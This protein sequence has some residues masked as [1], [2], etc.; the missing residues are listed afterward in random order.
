GQAEV[1]SGGYSLA[2]SQ[3]TILGAAKLTGRIGAFS[4]GALNAVTSDED[5]KIVNGDIRTRQTVEPLASYSVV[6]ARR[7]FTNQSSLGFLV[8]S[9]NRNLDAATR[10][11]PGQAYTGGMDGDWRLGPKYSIKGY[12]AGSSVHGDAG[13]IDALQRSTVHSFQRPDSHGL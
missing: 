12:L 10:F 1:P 7:E 11:L 3:T 2:P 6:R 5:A 13:A 8:T 4:V 9:T